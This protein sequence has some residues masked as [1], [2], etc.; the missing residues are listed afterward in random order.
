MKRSSQRILTTQVGSLPRPVEVLQ[1]TRGRELGKSF[2]DQE[3]AV[4]RA[5]VA[6][7]V[8][9][10][11]DCGIDIPSDGEYSKSSFSAYANERLAGF[12][13]K[14]GSR[15]SPS[16]DRKRFDEAYR[17][18][19]GLPSGTG[20]RT[21]TADV[22]C[23]GPI[24]YKGQ[25]LVAAD[26]AN[27]KAA[28]QGL[29]FAEAFVPAIGPGTFEMQRRND[30]YKT[31]EEYLFAIADAMATE[32]KMIVDA[33]F[34]LQIDDPRIL[35]EFDSMDPAPSAA[36]YRKFAGMRVDALNHALRGLPEDRVRYHVCWGSWHGPHT[37]D[38]PLIDI[39]EEL[40]RINAS[41]FSIEAA[42]PR[43]EHE[44]H[45]WEQVKFP[46]GKVMIPGVIAHTT[47]CVEHP[48][49]VAERIMRYA[50]LVGRENVIASTD[51]GFAQGAA[52]QR[53]HPTIVWEKFR[54]LAEG[55][56][57]ATQRLWS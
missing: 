38:L 6:E 8:R 21:G 22:A 41:A 56:R 43:H 3:Q 1:V 16:R 9:M 31:Q 33:G 50:N 23:T 44:Y 13:L 27:F 4:L 10:Q 49:L 48:E 47:N 7:A 14:P 57:L 35:T 30:Y 17:I 25:D 45:V 26:L 52:T 29:D 32:Y 46:G 37:T 11:A 24:S 18:I 40:L 2:T 19:D 5:S 28:L 12:E 15:S 36:D 51:C 42:N 54:M 53:V 34:I 20:T 39:A 55:A